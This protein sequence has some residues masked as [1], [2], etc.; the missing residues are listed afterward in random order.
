MKR[1]SVVGV[2]AAV[3]LIL[4]ILLG[5]G[6]ATAPSNV[7]VL[8]ILPHMVLGI[9]GIALVAYLAARVLYGGSMGVKILAILGFL[10]VLAQVALGFRIL[11]VPD[12]QLVMSHE[13][14]AFA[15]LVVIGLG[16]MLRA[17][18]AKKPTSAST[19]AK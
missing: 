19:A 13:G 2:I 12:D 3:G 18:Q 11:A 14:N 16:E 6:V 10:L 9:S 1:D 4:Q 15:I 5:F 17:R 7:S 8:L